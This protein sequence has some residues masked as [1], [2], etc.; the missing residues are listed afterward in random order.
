MS[1]K[2][3]DAKDSRT[4][5]EFRCKK[6]GR[7]LMRAR[8]RSLSKDAEAVADIEMNCSNRD[9]KAQNEITLIMIDHVKDLKDVAKPESKTEHKGGT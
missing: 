3:S 7:F 8:V 5:K 6:C 1:K 9:C 4:D 2:T